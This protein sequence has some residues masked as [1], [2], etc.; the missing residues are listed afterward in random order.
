MFPCRINLLKLLLLFLIYNPTLSK[1]HNQEQLSVKS[2][3]SSSIKTGGYISVVSNIFF[4]SD[5][6]QSVFPMN[7]V[8]FPTGINF[9]LS[10]RVAFSVEFVPTID[11][12]DGPKVKAF[13]FHPGVIYNL[14]KN[15]GIAGRIAFESNGQ[16][17]FT[18]V[19]GKTIHRFSNSNLSVSVPFPIRF[20]NDLPTNVSMGLQIGWGF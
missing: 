5:E 14:D 7:T 8:G 4:L 18:P 10:E 1:Q 13:L 16:I 20:G 3:S 17:G 19:F 11:F 2:S 9:S 15:H 12:S 6:E